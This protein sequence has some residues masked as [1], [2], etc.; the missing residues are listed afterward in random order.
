MANTPP[1][2]I[3]PPGTL[4][5]EEIEGRGWSVS[6]FAKILGRPIQVVSEI[7]NGKKAITPTTAHEIGE[8][9]GTGPEVW[10]N[11]ESMWQL[12]R[13]KKPG[14]SVKDRARLFDLAPVQD[15]QTR[16]WIDVGNSIESIESELTRFY[17]VT[18]LAERPVLPIAA[19]ALASQD[20]EVSAAQ[21]AWCFQAIRI[22][23]LV[24]AKPFSSTR[25]DSGFARL[26]ELAA[27]PEG[28]R[29]VPRV[30]SEMG[31]RLV[32]VK[33]LPRTR[34]DGAALLVDGD[35]PVIALSMRHDRIDGFWH[36]LCHELSHV[37][38]KDGYSIDEGLVGDD[39][40]DQGSRPAIEQRADEEAASFLIANQAMQ[41]FVVRKRP[42]FSKVSINQFAHRHQVHP[43]IVVG[44]LQHCKAIKY[45]H[46]REM[47]AKVRGILID[48][49]ITDGWGRVTT[50]D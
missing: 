11:L 34:I 48:E 42:Y 9:F 20:Q 25:F 24:E 18:S 13:A 7:L 41:S 6:E 47:L 4:I 27:H 26:R 8:A 50:V 43:G 12:A 46:S 3:S 17:R 38:H 2:A 31:V 32:V 30:L 5:R 22:A 40:D 21:L 35:K 49:A 19:R 14:G 10:I 33:H 29:S 45:S 23:G 1:A 15:M 44:Q 28:V 39:A 37:R 16:K 36:T